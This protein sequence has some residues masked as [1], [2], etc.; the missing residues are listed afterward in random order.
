M[1]SIGLDKSFNQ[2][3]SAGYGKT[4]TTAVLMWLK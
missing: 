2:G 3:F 1:T 4:I